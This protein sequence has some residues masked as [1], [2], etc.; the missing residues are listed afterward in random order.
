MDHV[1][2][3][4][5]ILSRQIVKVVEEHVYPRSVSLDEATHYGLARWYQLTNAQF[6]RLYCQ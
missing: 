4:W 5:L 3:I 2:K 6:I 1:E